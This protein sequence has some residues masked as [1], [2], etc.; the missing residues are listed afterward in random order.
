MNLFHIRRDSTAMLTY[1]YIL[2]QWTLYVVKEIVAH[3]PHV[4]ISSCI[5]IYECVDIVQEVLL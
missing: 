5:Y 3:T 1:T 4:Y 2:I